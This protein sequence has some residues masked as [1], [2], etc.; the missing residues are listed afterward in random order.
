MLCEHCG[1]AETIEGT[2][3]GTSFVPLSKRKRWIASGVYGIR[4]LACPGCGLLTS[5]SL[6]VESLRKI[7]KE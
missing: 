3:E 5:L 6:D 1:K 4:A 7:T 2:L